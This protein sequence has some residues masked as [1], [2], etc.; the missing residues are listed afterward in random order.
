MMRLIRLILFFLILI[1]GLSFAALN[2]DLVQLDYY[3]G[4]RQIPLSLILVVALALG[5]LIG[6]TACLG[7][8]LKQKREI[9]KLRK[10]VKTAETELLNQH[11]TARLTVSDIE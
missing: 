8:L 3:F 2:A 1:F 4:S 5:A 11:S 9:G 7:Q 6:A 10:A